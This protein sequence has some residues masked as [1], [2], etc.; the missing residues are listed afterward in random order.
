VGSAPARELSDDERQH[1]PVCGLPDG[2]YIVTASAGTPPE[3][4]AAAHLLNLASEGDRSSQANGFVPTDNYDSA[5]AVVEGRIVGG[6]IADRDRGA[7]LCVRLKPNGTFQSVGGP[8]KLCPIVFDLWV[9]PT[10]RRRG[11]G[12]QLIRAMATHFGRDVGELGFRVPFSKA[13]VQL[14]RAMELSTVLGVD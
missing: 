6:V 14:L 9:H 8:R 3:R 5:V 2:I 1:G 4:F 10:H 13:A 11:L 12:G 7:H